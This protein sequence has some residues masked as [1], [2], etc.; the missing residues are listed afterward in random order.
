LS[1]VSGEFRE[2][3]GG[4]TLLTAEVLYYLP[5]H[6]SVLQSFAWQTMDMAPRYPRLAAF[7]DHWRREIE[8]II[9]SVSVCTQGGVAPRRFRS[10]D[11]V[12]RLQ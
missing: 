1:K 4:A 3:L 10:V 11:E 7:L 2:R 8:A 12:F 6:P 9:H 5:D